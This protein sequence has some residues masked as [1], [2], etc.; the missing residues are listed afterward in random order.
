MALSLTLYTS[1]LVQAG[2]QAVDMPIWQL[3]GIYRVSPIST[4]TCCTC[5]RVEKSSTLA[6]DNASTT[7]DDGNLKAYG[8]STTGDEG[9]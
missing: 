8:A 9:T 4:P 3:Q 1:Y 7:G 6:V 2:P 5:S